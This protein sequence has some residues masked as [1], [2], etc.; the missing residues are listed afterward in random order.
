[1][2]KNILSLSIA[3]MIGGIGFAGV[4]SAGVLTTGATADGLSVSAGGTGHI[5]VVPYYTVQNGNATLLNLVNTDT[6]NGKEVKVRFRGA[7]NSDDVL[8][9]TLYLSPGDVWAAKVYRGDDGR[10]ALI[11]GDKSCTMPFNMNIPFKTGR[12]PA[13]FT[14]DQKAAETR[15]GYVEILN[16]ADIPKALQPG[17]SSV[18]GTVTVNPLYTETKHVAGVAPCSNAASARLTTLASTDFKAAVSAQ[19]AG[20]G[21]LSTE[22]AASAFG[23]TNPT[24]GLFANS[25]IINIP[26]TLTF[27]QEATAI[28]AVTVADGAS[29]KGNIVHTPQQ[30][31]SL[32]GIGGTY[33]GADGIAST[34]GTTPFTLPAAKTDANTVTADALLRSVNVARANGTADLLAS[35]VDA[36]Y[37]D[38]P[39]LS[40]PYAGGAAVAVTTGSPL[41]QAL[42]L[43]KAVA[44][45]SVMNE[46]LTTPGLSAFTDWTFSMPTRR[47]SVAMDYAWTSARG[48]SDGRVFTDLSGAAAA[49]TALNTVPS[50]SRFFHPGNTNVSGQQICTFGDVLNGLTSYDREE[51]TVGAAISASPGDGTRLQWCG[52]ASVLSFNVAAS[53]S[54]SVLGAA[55]A[56]GF[57]TV[58]GTEGWAKIGTLGAAAIAAPSS[59]IVTGEWNGLPVIGAFYTKAVNTAVSAGVSGSYGLVANHRYTK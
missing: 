2:R 8:D 12:L 27:T 23:L 28:T 10:A 58:I 33:T 36:T 38:I 24:G 30:E 57:V 22:L 45:K 55:I 35:I 16:T 46:Y 44:V 11:T 31:I 1:M 18:G 9:F 41:V 21:A 49:F 25:T 29:K 6:S 59:P 51:T 32:A 17:Q 43:T 5:L 15:E 34:S 3:A 4:A 26:S 47:Y 40:T 54:T 53:A 19:P 13:S 56:P 42:T 7:S 14:A 39:D 52:E 20:T 50:T 48:G 37:Q